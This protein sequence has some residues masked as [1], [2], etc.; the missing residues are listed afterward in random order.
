MATGTE[1]VLVGRVVD[2]SSESYSYFFFLWTTPPRI[3]LLAATLLLLCYLLTKKG[4]KFFKNICLF[5]IAK[6]VRFSRE[7]L[8]KVKSGSLITS[9]G[10]H[11]HNCIM[12]NKG[13]MAGN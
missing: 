4:F 9:R 8:Q 2:R 5:Y 7:L 6:M 12:G 3:A 1:R 11:A 10:V 13:K